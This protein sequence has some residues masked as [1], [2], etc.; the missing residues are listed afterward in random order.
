MRFGWV[1]Y[2]DLW[3]DVVGGSAECLGRLVAHD[4]LL[5]HAEVGDLDMSVL[6]EEHVVQLE[7]AVD[8]P[9]VVEVEQPDRD[10]SGV[11]PAELYEIRT[12]SRFPVLRAKEL[13]KIITAA[14]KK[15]EK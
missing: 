4:V 5:A 13:R 15:K 1:L 2:A 12:V 8:D 7:V 3:G 10:L 6:V 14:P 9:A 11:E